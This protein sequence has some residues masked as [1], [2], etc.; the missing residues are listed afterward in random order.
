MTA[1]VSGLGKLLA[2]VWHRPLHSRTQPGP[3]DGA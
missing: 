1:K 3:A 2:P